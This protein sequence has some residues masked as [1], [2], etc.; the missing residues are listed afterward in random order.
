M[1]NQKSKRISRKSLFRLFESIGSEEKLGIILIDFYNRMS[2]DILIGFFFNK[3][4]IKAIA[5]KQK[6]F[7]L[8]AFG[9]R[10]SYSGKPPASAHKE[11]P[12]ILSGHFDRRL[13]ILEETLKEHGLSE[14]NI[15]EWIAFEMTFRKQIVVLDPAFKRKT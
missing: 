4:D 1:Q 12:S 5:L 13:K 15:K 7:L 14:N 11:L 3:K 2:N 9:A 10:D 6:D 8:R